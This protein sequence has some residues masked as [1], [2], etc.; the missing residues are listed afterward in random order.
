MTV[1]QTPNYII[2]PTKA[3]LISCTING[4]PFVEN[5]SG[6]PLNIFH[7]QELRIFEDN[8]KFYFTGQLVI[9]AHQNTF[10]QYVEPKAP[11]E[12]SFI[13]PPNNKIYTERFRIYSYE[14]KPREGD[15]ENSMIITIS[16]LGEEY[17][18]DKSEQVQMNISNQIATHAIRQIHEKYIKANGNIDVFDSLGMIGQQLHPHQILSK[19]PS[20]AIHDL[21]DKAVF[22]VPSSGPGVYFRSKNGY[23]VA[24]LEYLIT[25]APITGNFVHVPAGGASLDI[26]LRGYDKVINFRPMAPPGEDR[27]AASRNEHEGLNKVPAIVDLAQGIAKTGSGGFGVK[28]GSQISKYV[29]DSLRQH[30]NI[31]KN[32][33]GGFQS[34][35]DAFITKL[36]YSPKYWTSVPMQTGIDVTVGDRIQITYPISDRMIGVKKLWVARLI[37]ELRFTEGKDRKEVTVNGTTDIFGVE[38]K[39]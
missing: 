16:L 39:G 8:C 19:A 11:V 20:K 21:L 17:F 31:D 25:S 6:Q 7:V 27:S 1:Q 37:H 33:P 15:I 35:E 28:Y 36:T 32:G 24:P 9:E 3:A 2:Q 10:E 29:A 18:K 14:S 38:L 22:P 13:S 23:V 26:T 4:V 5:R 30:L 12:I 34:K